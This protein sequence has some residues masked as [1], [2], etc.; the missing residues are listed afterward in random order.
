MPRSRFGEL[1]WTKTEIN[2]DQETTR[3]IENWCLRFL[4]NATDF[5]YMIGKDNKVFYVNKTSAA[6]FGKDREDIVGKSIFDLFPEELVKNYARDLKRTFQTVES[7]YYEAQMI[8]EEREFRTSVSLSPI[9][10]ED[11][12]IKAVVD[13]TRDVSGRK[14][15][16]EELKKH[17]TRLEARDTGVGFP[18]DIDFRNTESL[19][20]QI[21]N[22][23]VKQLN[24]DMRLMHRGGTVF[25]VTF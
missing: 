11:G 4:D 12:Q 10:V 17:Q 23:L 20:P 6:L 21:V 2:R 24:G 9:K 19:G 3:E 15:I 14:L 13:V 22:D 25:R 7:G 16:E 8:A 1:K 18:P 5:I